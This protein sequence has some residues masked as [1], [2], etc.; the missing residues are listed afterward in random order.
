MLT[1]QLLLGMCVVLLA[2]IAGLLGGVIDT[3]REIRTKLG[4]SPP[5]ASH[6]EWTGP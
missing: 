3:L 1:V 4:P 6:R 5:L 2:I